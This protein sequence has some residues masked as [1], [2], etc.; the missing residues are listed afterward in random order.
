MKANMILG[1]ALAGLL[2]LASTAVEAEVLILTPTQ[3]AVCPADESGVTKVV[4]QFDLSGITGGE[5]RQIDQALLEW[6]VTGMPSG[7]HSEYELHAATGAWT[8]SAVASGTVPTFG[9]DTADVW[10]Y[11]P[12]DYTRNQGGLLR[13]DLLHLVRGW[14]AGEATNYGVVI[15]TEDLSRAGL[16]NQLSTIRLTI[17][18]GFVPE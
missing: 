16:S 13:L 7:T 1:V 18:Y 15:A 6:V 3:S 2:A 8:E 9:E 14:L 12:L 5:G 11:S 17:R 4:L 10:S